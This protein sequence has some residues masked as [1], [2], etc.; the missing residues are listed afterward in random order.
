LVGQELKAFLAEEEA[1]RQYQKQQEEQQAMLREVEIAKGQLRL[2][3]D[4][5]TTGVDTAATSGGTSGTGGDAAKATGPGGK[6]SSSTVVKGRPKKKSRFD[7]SLFLKFSKP[8]HCTRTKMLPLLTLGFFFQ[9]FI[10][11]CLL[12]MFLLSRPIFSNL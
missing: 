2:G 12:S 11:T 5:G 1:K 7:S 4:E 10:L 3:E 6:T 9:T 8:L